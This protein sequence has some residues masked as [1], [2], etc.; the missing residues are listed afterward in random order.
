MI[1][2]LV[3]DFQVL[4][5]ADALI[6]RIWLNFAGRRFGLFIFAGL[7]AVFGLAMANVAGFFA[8]QAKT[9]DVGA[10]TAMAAIDLIIA[11]AV[12]LL[13]SKSRPGPELEV[14]Y[15]VRKMATDALA[16]DAQG[17]KL[18]LD[19]VGRELREARASIAGLVSNPLDV[20]AQKLLI[21]A[22][23]SIMRNVRAKKSH[24]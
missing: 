4:H 3:R 13:A 23:L 21:P 7:V 17:F 18:A 1:D 9:G 16:T 24:S 22:A 14:A 2:N 10:A 19:E 11:A 5:K 20:A 15:E 12:V 8:L 6:A